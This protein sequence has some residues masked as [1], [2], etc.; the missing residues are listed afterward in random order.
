MTTGPATPPPHGPQ[1]PLDHNRRRTLPA[2]LAA[3]LDDAHR[4]SGGTY[5]SVAAAIGIDWSFWR[6]LT[7]GERCPSRPVAW[8]ICDVLQVPDDV[9]DQLM[10]AAV[11]RE[12]GRVVA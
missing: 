8:R 7:R 3:A 10:A 9:A 6:R 5:R 2:D 12:G 1:Q 11:V 4:R